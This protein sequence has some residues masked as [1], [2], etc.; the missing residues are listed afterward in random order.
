MS[1][2]EQVRMEE[3]TELVIN[4]KIERRDASQK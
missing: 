4:E 2:D 1:R 3:K